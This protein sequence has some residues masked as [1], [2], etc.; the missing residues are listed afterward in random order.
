VR[1]GFP[2]AE[3]AGEHWHGAA[4][5]S[6]MVHL[7]LYE[8]T[9]GGDGASWFGHVTDEQYDIAATAAQAS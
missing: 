5:D 1:K 9:A 3:L 8:G 7:A 2:A 6:F 4:P